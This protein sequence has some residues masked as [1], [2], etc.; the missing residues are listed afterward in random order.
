MLYWLEYL[1]CIQCIFSVTEKIK[2]ILKL[3]RTAAVLSHAYVIKIKYLGVGHRNILC[4]PG[5]RVAVEGFDL[6]RW[7]QNLEF[8]PYL[9]FLWFWRVSFVGL[10]MQLLGTRGHKGYSTMRCFRWTERLRIAWPG[11][12]RLHLG[13]GW[14][15]A[16]H[17]CSKLSKKW[18]ITQVERHQPIQPECEAEQAA[19]RLPK[20]FIAESITQPL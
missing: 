13:A 7:R 2:A 9:L 8:F 11:C 19:G 14:G 10:W 15:K 5:C 6:F 4:I 18:Q 3:K 12:C 17:R 16:A 20:Y 1:D